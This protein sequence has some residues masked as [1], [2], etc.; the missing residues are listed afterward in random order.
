MA[1]TVALQ[2]GTSK[3]RHAANISA[4]TVRG[5]QVFSFNFFVVTV[6]EQR[7]RATLRQPGWDSPR[8]HPPACTPNPALVD[9]LKA[10]LEAAA[11]DLDDKGALEASTS[12]PRD[13]AHAGC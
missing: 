12:V 4:P 13:C 5:C 7:S 6:R 3:W 8:A 2:P 9:R 1:R 10:G 11:P